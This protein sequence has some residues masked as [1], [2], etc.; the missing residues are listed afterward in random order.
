M[1]GKIYTI[2]RKLR[3]ICCSLVNLI[4][5]MFFKVNLLGKPGK[6]EGILTIRSSRK[7]AITIGKKVQFRSGKGYNII[8]GDTRLILRAYRNGSIT[9]GN[10]VGISNSAIVS[11]NHIEIE[12]NV[13]IGGSCKIWDT[14]FHSLNVVNRLMPYDTDIKSAPICIKRGAF[15]GAQSIILKGVTIGEN[16]IIGAGSVVTK[17]IPEGQIWAGNP[18][19]YVREVG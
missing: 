13:F 6:M 17:D 2:F 10:N 8:G 15:I 19:R 16:S 11:M 4:S 14:D 1:I 12:D 18:A 5:F 7:G 3:D 9:I